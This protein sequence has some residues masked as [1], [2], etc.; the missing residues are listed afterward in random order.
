MI[1]LSADTHFS[2]PNIIKFCKRPFTTIHEMNKTLIQNWNKIVQPDDLV[3]FLGDLTIDKRKASHFLDQLNGKIIFI[4]GNHDKGRSIIENHPKIIETYDL[5]MRNIYGRSFTFCHFAMRVWDKSHFGKSIQ[6]YG[7]SHG[8]LL[9]IG[10]QLDVGVDNAA[11]LLGEYRPFRLRE[12][13]EII[14]GD[15]NIDGSN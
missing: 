11:K 5:L 13:L 6:L 10:N 9:P 12:V 8:S 3:Y 14:E 2:H 15:E 1:Y 4:W 7:H